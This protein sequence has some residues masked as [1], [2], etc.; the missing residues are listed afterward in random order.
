MAYLFALEAVRPT[1][2]YS[3]NITH[4]L[5]K[6]ADA[7]GLYRALWRPEEI[8]I[9]RAGEL[10]ELL[11]R[12]L[13]RLKSGD[14]EEFRKLDPENGW[15][16]YDGLVRFVESYLDGCRAAPDALIRFTLECDACGRTERRDLD[17]PEQRKD[18]ERDEM[19]GW[20]EIRTNRVRSSAAPIAS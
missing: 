8:G 19:I 1:T 6:L 7:V 3:A 16:D 20:G 12:G 15:G 11:E 17:E 5:K 10:V 13:A 4:N 9:T 14:R 2:V 18:F